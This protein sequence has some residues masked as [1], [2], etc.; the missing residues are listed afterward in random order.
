MDEAWVDFQITIP[1][2]MDAVIR[3]L[4]GNKDF[5]ERHGHDNAIGY[6]IEANRFRE[7][8]QRGGVKLLSSQ[9][10]GRGPV[11]M[12]NLPGVVYIPSQERTLAL[13][14]ER[15]KTP[16][17]MPPRDEFIFRWSP[18]KAWKDSLEARLYGARWDD[19][20][21]KE[22]GRPA[23]AHHFEAYSQAFERF[24]EGTKRLKWEQGDLIV[25]TRNGAKHDLSEL[26]SGEKQVIVLM[27]EL[28]QHWRPGSLVLIDEPELHLHS[29]WQTRLWEAL[30]YWQ[31]ERGGQVI[32]A[33]QSNHLFLISNPRN[34]V[35]LGGARLA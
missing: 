9:L 3:Y 15:Y 28:L 1:G 8:F 30:E 34:S 13:L 19:L 20:N 23:D 35:L 10:H 29:H 26:S 31:R 32:V 4:F 14:E 5:I 16:G 33:T 25:E 12:S 17:R 18:P 24:F 27:A 2:A 6:I 7:D 22:E 11:G 21:A